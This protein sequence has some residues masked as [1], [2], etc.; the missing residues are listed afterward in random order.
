MRPCG[1]VSTART[2]DE[3]QAR[4]ERVLM[5]LIPKWFPGFFKACLS[6]LPP[7][8][9]ARHAAAIT[10]YVLPWLVGP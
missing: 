2:S 8:F 9:A 1:A 5:A 7:W 10:P 3:A 4:G 6:V